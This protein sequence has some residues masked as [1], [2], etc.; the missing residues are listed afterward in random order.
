MQSKQIDLMLSSSK[1]P[2][3]ALGL[4]FICCYLISRSLPQ[5]NLSIFILF[6]ILCL[7]WLFKYLTFRPYC[8]NINTVNH[9]IK[10]SYNNQISDARLIKCKHIAW[11]LSVIHLQVENKRYKIYLFA[12]SVPLNLYKSFKIYSQ[13]T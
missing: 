9:N 12:D 4:L 1:I 8:L 3:Y 13:W 10:F 2:T 7:F 6:A 11:W 5:T